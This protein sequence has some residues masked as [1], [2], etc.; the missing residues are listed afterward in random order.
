MALVESGAQNA[1]QVHPRALDHAALAAV[2]VQD[3]PA[4]ADKIHA[5]TGL[6]SHQVGLMLREVLRFMHLAAYCGHK[7]GPPRLLDLAWHEFILFTRLYDNFCRRYLG[8]FIHHEPGGD[9]DTNRG[10]LQQ[11]L[12]FYN[13][14]FGQ[15]EPRFWGEHGYLSEPTDCGSCES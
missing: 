5:A 1:T 7:L 9:R 2:L 8:R 14:Y 12:K 6:E 13:L 11:T 4:L 15:P 3:Y 10:Q